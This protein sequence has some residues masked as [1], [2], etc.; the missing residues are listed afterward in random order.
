MLSFRDLLSGFR[1]LGIEDSRPMIVHASL[2]SFGEVRGEAET[3]LGALL[4]LHPRLMA[5]AHTYLTMIIP[6]NGP[7]HN[8]MVYGSGTDLNR[9]AEFYRPDMPCDR[10]MGALPETLRRHP[11]A[12]RSYHPILSFTGIGVE[13]ELRLQTLDDPLA[14]IG[15][16]VEEDGWVLLL[17]VDNTVNTSI[18]W[19]E[20]L[21]GRRQ[22][23]RWALTKKGVI[24]CRGFPGCSLG[25]EQISP[26]LESITR[27]VV[28]GAATVRAVPLRLLVETAVEMIREDVEALLCS[29]PACERCAAVRER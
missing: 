15:A 4:Q 23:I 13:N 11:M 16:L 18:H 9:M 26:R 3:L 12:R 29:D 20:K 27:T 28:V 5:P 14:P 1:A 17:G 22:F 24:E 10:L 19:A 6:E 7:D 21:A 2:S 25:F 8:G